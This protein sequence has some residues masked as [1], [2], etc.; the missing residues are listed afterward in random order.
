M[1]EKKLIAELQR[2]ANRKSFRMEDLCFPEQLAF[3]KDPAKFKAGLCS[4]RCLAKDTLVQTTL[5]PKKIQDIVP[6]DFVYNEFGLPVKVKDTFSNGSREV[7]EVL[8]NNKI[9]VEATLDHNFLTHHSRINK[10]RCR[11]LSKFYEGVKIVRNEV[12]RNGGVAVKYAYAIGALLGDGCSRIKHTSY[13]TISS[14]NEM[15][16]TKVGELLGATLVRKCHPNNF[17]Y[18]I[19]LESVPEEYKLW[20]EKRYAHE[21][22]CDTNRLLSWDRPSRLAFIAGLLDTDG[23]VTNNKDG[24]QLGISM[25]AKSVI[26]AVVVLFQ[27]LWGYKPSIYVDNRD[28]YK[29]GPVYNLRLKHNYFGKKIL[30]DLS[31]YIMTPRKQ[32]KPEYEQKIENN[33]NANYVG[34]KLG[35]KSIKET[36][37]IHVDSPTNLYMLANGLITHNSGKSVACAIDLLHTALTQPGDVAYITLNRKTAKRILWRTLME[38]INEYD[39]EAKVDNT[40]LTLTLPNKNMIHLSGAKDESEIEKLRGLYF[41]K[42]YIDEAQA[43][44]EYIRGLI[45]DVIEPA[46]TDYDGSLI[47]IGTPGPI[48]VGYFYDATTNPNWAHHNWTM[49]QNPWILKKSGKTADVLIKEICDRRGVSMDSPSILREFYGKWIRDEDSL[50]FKFSQ[51]KNIYKELPKSKMEYIFGID[52]GYE[53]ADAIAVL[54]YS[55]ED[56]NVYLVEE[57]VANK[58]NISSLVEQIEKMR[59]IYN[60]VKLMMDAGALGKKIQDE[61][62]MRHGIPVEAADK[63]RKLEY[64]ELLNDDLRT[65]KLLVHQGSRFEQDSYKVQWDYD[66]SKPKVSDSYHTDIGDALLYA[67]RECKHYFYAPPPRKA[68]TPDE[69]MAEYWEREEQALKDAKDGN[70]DIVPTSSDMDFIC[71]DDDEI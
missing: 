23:S 59:K 10:D 46:L 37:D 65:G 69:L 34:I 25:Q 45:E 43:F 70:K 2:R 18:N 20:C 47:L 42:V 48:P 66:G 39:I 14:E 35:K 54:G 52:I 1:D 29:N 40:E 44:R 5:G 61:I 12:D 56:K 19:Y 13:I 41:R 17:N 21:K 63:N 36:Y 32:F 71:G 24:I 57:Y 15:I 58:Q 55:Y 51:S 22:V 4:R 67:W 38:Y 31:P 8:Q 49:H 7:V 6:G 33:F 60:P 64:I 50:V 27:D 9:L 26:D 68:E 3:L 16:P 62:R 30:K 11:P 53:D 28:K